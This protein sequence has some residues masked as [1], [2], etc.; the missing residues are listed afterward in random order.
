MVHVP[1]VLI[2]IFGSGHLDSLL[3]SYQQDSSGFLPGAYE[4]SA[5]IIFSYDP[6]TKAQDQVHGHVGED[7]TSAWKSEGEIC[8]RH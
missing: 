3:S 8:W 1:G 4:V 7:Y 5:S 2:P 6:L